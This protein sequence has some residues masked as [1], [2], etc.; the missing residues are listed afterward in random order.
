MMDLGIDTRHNR[1]MVKA[2]SAPAWAHQFTRRW[3]AA[4]LAALLEE[5]AQG[6][7]LSGDALQARLAALGQ[8]SPL[9]RAQI[10]RLLDGLQAFL[11]QLASLN[12]RID[13]PPRKRT[14]GPWRLIHEGPLDFEVDGQREAMPWSYAGLTG[15]GGIDALHGL[16]SRLLI[17]DA[18]AVEGHYESAIQSLSPLDRAPVSAEAQGLVNLRLCNWHRHLGQFQAAQ[19]CAQ[20]VLDLPA[21]AD[22]GLALHARFFLERIRYDQNPAGNWESLW[23]ST[24]EEP[25]PA[26]PGGLDWRTRSEWHN[27]RALL[28]RRRMHQLDS[29]PE[30][31]APAVDTLHQLALRHFQ[32]ALY[33]ALWSRDWSTLQAY[34]A[35]LAFHLQSCLVLRNEVGVGPG[36]VLGWH[37]LTMAYSDKLG[38]GRD[39]AWEYIFFAKFWLDHQDKLQ[40]GTVPDPLA[41]HLG[42]S[43]PD[44][45]AFYVQALKRLR[46]CGD[47]RQVAIGHCLYLR[48][49]KEH[50]QGEERIE[51]IQR[52]CQK[53]TDLLAAQSTPN[54]FQSLVAEGYA[55]HWPPALSRSFARNGQLTK[56]AHR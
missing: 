30:V 14:V 27:L 11:D 19:A 29:E 28:A 31:Q 42:R 32:A 12:A 21:P 41:H 5:A 23:Q 1:V 4:W 47:D 37:R 45:E 38:A 6:R 25:R 33:M 34:V 55:V 10:Q 22:P 24:A 3:E 56:S 50:M 39:S 44:Q 9:N 54:L 15:A 13:S 52:Q 7:A 46:E 51:A 26:G 18:L 49:A 2:P 40:P 17:A 16:L 48:F 35:N 36:Q 53:L 43:S 20:S 8:S